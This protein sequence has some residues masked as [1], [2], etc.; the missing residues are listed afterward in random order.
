MSSS[1]QADRF[2]FANGFYSLGNGVMAAPDKEGP[3][4]RL[5]V[6][7][8]D[9]ATL[10]TG[11]PNPPAI[12][13]EPSQPVTPETDSRGEDVLIKSFRMLSAVLVEGYWI[14]FVTNG[15][16]LFD[17]AALSLFD[18]TP[19]HVDHGGAHNLHGSA[20]GPPSVVNW[21]G[22]AVNARRSDKP[23]VG[24][25][26]DFR[27]SREQD[28]VR[29][30]GSICRGLLFE[31]PAITCCSVTVYFD[32]VK[33]HPAM[34]NYD[35]WCHMGEVVDGKL[36]CYVA[37][38]FKRITEVSLVYAG[39]DELARS[40]S[41]PGAAKNSSAFSL[42]TPPT[43]PGAAP[44]PLLPESAKAA[45]AAPPIADPAPP[46][47]AEPATVIGEA[48][49]AMTTT[50]TDPTV[51][52]PPAAPAA[53]LAFQSP[54]PKSA[55]TERPMSLSAAEKATMRRVLAFVLDCY[56]LEAEL[57]KLADDDQ[58]G[59]LPW[60]MEFAEHVGKKAFEALRGEADA[61]EGEY[62][63]ATDMAGRLAVLVKHLGRP[64]DRI[65]A[66][67]KAARELA[68]KTATEK[69]AELAKQNTAGAGVLT[70][71][72]KQLGVDAADQKALQ[73][74]TMQH[75]MD[76]ASAPKPKTEEERR[77]AALEAARAKNVPPSV[78]LGV[79]GMDIDQLE[80][81]VANVKGPTKFRQPSGKK[82]E[83]SAHPEGAGAAA[84]AM[85]GSAPQ[86]PEDI[87]VNSLSADQRREYAR[88]GVTSD[89]DLRQAEFLRLS[90]VVY[91]TA[92]EGE[93]DE[94]QE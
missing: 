36:V 88:C 27:F 45:A 4:T 29:Y 37:T 58:K 9:V 19:I 80:K 56:D 15:P 23:V 85:T 84:A 60:A 31:P 25:D 18:N 33:S 24:F 21:I 90:R 83:P 47:V 87:D 8:R 12:K 82:F 22:V 78:L 69:A 1:T 10:L 7:L 48:P 65:A 86:K 40:L 73:L 72:A 14:D 93:E 52:P 89:E 39:A 57:K 76:A 53:V 71:L 17:D 11:N 50:P 34:D 59:K 75:F 49:A 91:A 46:I 54:A 51:E 66:A 6:H 13:T 74:A 92:D 3:G 5:G 70:Y 43:P 32:G 67:V 41:A 28:R 94:A 38:K 77:A 42:G 26:A 55:S 20:W 81:F 79:E 44:Q 63:A 16:S 68:E 35:F 62:S 64:A 61:M 30:G 2:P